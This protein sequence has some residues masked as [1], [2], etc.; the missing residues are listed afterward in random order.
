MLQDR[1]KCIRQTKV[2]VV[3]AINFLTIVIK[4]VMKATFFHLFLVVILLPLFSA[5]R[6][7]APS[8]AVQK[9]QN[10]DICFKD[11]L[12]NF[13]IIPL[14]QPVDS[15]DFIFTNCGKDRLV[16]LGV[17][18]SCHCTKVFYPHI[19]IEPD[20]ESFVRVIYDGRER[21]AEYFSKS[22]RV[23]TNA[24]KECVTLGIN[25]RLQ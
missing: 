15:F 24:K 17:E 14:L 7:S 2:S 11:T 9:I 20:G 13:G 21:Q 8:S 22:I 1:Y 10:A 4:Y 5:C 19:P 16:I 3:T 12:H 6:K 23:I 18:T 25:G